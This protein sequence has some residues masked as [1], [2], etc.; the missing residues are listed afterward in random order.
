MKIK[1][2]RN[3]TVVI[4][5]EDELKYKNGLINLKNAVKK[6]DNHTALFVLR[7][8]RPHKC[9]SFPDYLP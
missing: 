4:S 6:E 8:Y 7:G 1:A 5:S 9:P 3:K 2:P